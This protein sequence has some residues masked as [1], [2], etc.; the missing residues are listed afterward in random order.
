MT[1]PGNPTR[2]VRFFRGM[3]VSAHLEYQRAME[4]LLH[5]LIIVKLCSVMSS[6]D[7]KLIRVPSVA[8]MEAQCCY[9]ACHL[10]RL[11]EALWHFCALEQQ[12][13]NRHVVESV[14]E[15]VEDNLVV[16]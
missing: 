5:A 14:P 8:Q 16:E 12:E 1:R 6:P 13:A 2:G 7:E 3:A 9:Q 15:V 4:L 10:L 11:F